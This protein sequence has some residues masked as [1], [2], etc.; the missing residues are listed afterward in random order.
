MR[1]CR[2]KR[3]QKIAQIGNFGKS[4]EVQVEHEQLLLEIRVLCLPAI[5]D[6]DL[7]CSLQTPESC[8]TTG[9]FKNLYKNF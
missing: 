4:P 5:R 9:Y 6:F 8:V 7:Q 2:G 3:T 1:S